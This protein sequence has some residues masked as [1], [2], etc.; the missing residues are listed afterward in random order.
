MSILTSEEVWEPY[1][2][3]EGVAVGVIREKTTSLTPMSLII[4]CKRNIQRNLLRNDFILRLDIDTITS[5]QAETESKQVLH[6]L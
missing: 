4:Y 2:N 1:G 3:F 5:L 6:L